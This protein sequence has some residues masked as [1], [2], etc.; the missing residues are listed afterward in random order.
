MATYSPNLR[1]T[2][3]TNGTETGTWGDTTNTNLGT[4]ID[5]AIAGYVAVTTTS[6]SQALTASNGLADQSRNM[7][8]KLDTSA[9]AAYTVY[10]PPAEKY[11]VIYNSNSTYAV[12][13]SAATALNGTTPT[14]GTTVTIPAGKTMPIFCDGTNIRTALDYA[15]SLVLGSALP[16]ASGGTGQVT[17][18]AAINALLPSQAAAN[19]LV[20]SSDGTNVLWA[21]LIPA[22]TNNA[23]S[24]LTTDGTNTSWAVP[25]VKTVLCA[26]TANLTSLAGTLTID[27]I[28]VVAGNRVLVKDQTATA[29]NGIYVVAAGSWARADDASTAAEIAGSFVNIQSGS[30]NGGTQ[31]V[32]TFKSTNLVGTDAMAWNSVVSGTITS[33]VTT[34]SFSGTGLTPATATSGAVAVAGTLD[35]DNGG[36]G[37]SSYAVGDILY[38]S[39]STAL[40]KLADVA[41]GNA[42]I[43]GGV[44]VAPSYGK[45]GLTT[46]V[47]GTLPVANGGTNLTTYAV[48]D[49]VYA[50]GATT[51]ASLADVATGNALISGG[52]GVAP[53]YGKIGLATHVSGNLPVTNLNSGTSASA[54]T[55]WRGDGSW[56][57]PA[58]GTGTVT[59]VGMTVPTGFAVSPST[60]T[61]TGTFAITYSGVAI[62]TSNGG[63]GSTATTFCNLTTNVSGTLPATNGGTGQSTYAVGDL[64]VGGATNT[65]A[66]LADVA[67]GNALI[68]G[69]VGV[70]PSYGKIGLTTHVSGT[71]PTANGGTGSTATTYCNLTTNVT[72][73]LPVT[74]LGSGTSA[75]ATTFWRGDGTWATPASASGNY[76][77]EVFTSGGIWNAV[78][79]LKFVKVTVVGG[80][81][82]GA[83]TTGTSKA[84]TQSGNGGGGASAVAFMTAAQAGTSQTIAVGSGGGG[85]TSSFG[86]IVSC[87]GGANGGATNTGAGGT[88]TIGT[89]TSSYVVN[90]MG[91]SGTGIRDM[92]SS[93][94]GIGRQ[95]GAVGTNTVGNGAAGVGYGAGGGGAVGAG[96]LV[97]GGSGTAGI[98]IVESYY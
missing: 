2:L 29:A 63:T 87:T 23:N 75:S 88:A 98:V 28:A 6:A 74:N 92:G 17:A 78:A 20:L 83:N 43:S 82:N 31:Y 16:I 46:H 51:L 1:I 89:V 44:G 11:Y 60:I 3:I 72:G 69:G 95:N 9:G 71:L 84:N 79:G 93:M 97:T 55:F 32:T 27:G 64:L 94:L 21:S 68:S 8:I 86:S 24:F 52:V 30:A 56:A 53:S 22:Q 35:A 36:T 39:T 58:S 5:D 59:S 61:S 76:K 38:A 37:Q 85:A 57:T 90:G 81:G 14:G 19:G 25:G 65:L 26:T 15:S 10:I 33:G 62:P 4:I 13:I 80:G 40:S 73:N 47:S 18:S 66:K 70:A 50:S 49:I 77:M 41:T 34:I 96:T 48:G 12:T 54:T 91:T 45:V 42:L 7:V 67:T